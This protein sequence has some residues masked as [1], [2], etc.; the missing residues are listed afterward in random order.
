MVYILFQDFVGSITIAP[1][2]SHRTFRTT[3][4]TQT[5]WQI[6]NCQISKH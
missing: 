3:F 1:T 5:T 2:P 6:S 4:R